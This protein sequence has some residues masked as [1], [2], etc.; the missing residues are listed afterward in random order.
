VLEC[1]ARIGRCAASEN[2]PGLDELIEG[3][4]Q[5]GLRQRGNGGEQRLGELAPDHRCHLRRVLHRCEAIEAR[6]E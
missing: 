6:E 3:A 5:L 2:Q 1:V 4:T